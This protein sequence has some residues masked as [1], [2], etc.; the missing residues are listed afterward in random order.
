MSLPFG[1]A[2]P[3]AVAALAQPVEPDGGAASLGRAI[4]RVLE[5]AGQAGPS[6]PLAELASAAAAEFGVTAA[7]VEQHAGTILRHP[8]GARFF[9]GAQILWSGNE[10]AVSDGGEVL[11]IDRLVQLAE[12]GAAVWW[13]LDY[14]LHRAPEAHGPYR[15]QLLRYREAVRVAQPGQPVRCAFVTGEGRIVEIA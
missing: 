5:W 11:R 13:V 3:V 7:A 15:Q 10:V 2:K 12:S 6:A 1:D 14:K 4:H 9:A 8:E